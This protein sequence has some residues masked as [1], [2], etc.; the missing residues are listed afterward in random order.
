MPR[1]YVLNKIDAISIEELELRVRVP[2]FVLELT[3]S[4]SSAVQA[5][6]RRPRACTSANKDERD[7]Q[8]TVGC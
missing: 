8:F 6:L 2:H 4:S 5:G 7:T 1:L 3:R